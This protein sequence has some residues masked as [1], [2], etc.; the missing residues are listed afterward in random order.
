MLISDYFEITTAVA[1]PCDGLT[2]VKYHPVHQYSGVIFILSVILG[3]L[4]ADI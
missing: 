1:V 2:A 4:G 3:L